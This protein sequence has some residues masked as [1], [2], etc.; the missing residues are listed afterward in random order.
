MSS[1]FL[2]ALAFLCPFAGA[3]V[4][5]TVR[6][7]LPSH[8]LN[9]DS[10]DVIKL[11]TGLIGTLVA[12]VLSLLISSANSVHGEVET[13]YKQAIAGVGQL[14][15]RL[16]A[17]G[18]EAADIREELR[19]IVVSA[20]RLRWPQEDF[21]TAPSVKRPITDALLD[22]ERRILKLHPADDEQRWFRDQALQLT[23]NLVQIE[24][25]V[26]NQAA[27]GSL[28]L[29]VLI[30]VIACAAAIF[31]SFGLYVQP[32]PTVVVA[33]AASAL[34]VAGAVFLIV[35]LNTPFSGLMQISSAPLKALLPSLG[36]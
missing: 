15:Q 31:G 33:L 25:M 6:D 19:R 12:L 16:R 14:D 29:P 4:G 9:R 11:A 22:L 34:A 5:L 1:I 13:E 30:A 3:A 26:S 17:Y 27:G 21:G 23:G 2:G 36:T 10:I 20:G 18:P 32:N 8:H 28:P 7:R 35:E 24:R